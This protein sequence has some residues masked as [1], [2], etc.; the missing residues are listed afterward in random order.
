MRCESKSN[1]RWTRDEHLNFL[2]GKLASKR[3]TQSLWKKL[4]KNL[5]VS[6]DQV[7]LSDPLSCPK[8]FLEAQGPR[9]E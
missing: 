6:S 4:E 7:R 3:R 2:E 1:G 9:E 5:T 8:V